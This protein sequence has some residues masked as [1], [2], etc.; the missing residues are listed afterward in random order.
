MIGES[1]IMGDSTMKERLDDFQTMF[2]YSKD[3]SK[4]NLKN[5]NNTT[6]ISNSKDE[7]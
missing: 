5:N 2:E 6:I 7:Y 4:I 3:L 1:D